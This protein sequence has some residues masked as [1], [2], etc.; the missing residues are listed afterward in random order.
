MQE[1]ELAKC[2]FEK[3]LEIDPKNE[4]AVENLKK[5]EDMVK[6]QES[7]EKKSGENP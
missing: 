7:Q 6:D 4:S 1:P 5:C 3:L 2:E